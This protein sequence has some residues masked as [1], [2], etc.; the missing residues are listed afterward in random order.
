MHPLD[1]RLDRRLDNDLAR[2]IDRAISI[3]N[4]EGSLKAWSHLVQVGLS[5][6]AIRRVLALDSGARRRRRAAI[7]FREAEP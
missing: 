2:E 3:E 1:R 7:P 6:N 4:M 5:P